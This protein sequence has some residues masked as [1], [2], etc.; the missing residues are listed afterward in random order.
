MV[1]RGDDNIIRK[2]TMKGLKTEGKKEEG[3]E[4]EKKEVMISREGGEVGRGR[5]K[6]L[7]TEVRE[8][9]ESRGGKER[10]GDKQGGRRA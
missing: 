7:K 8:Q 6:G 9:G 2:G 3:L 10:S 4:K 1:G 5:G